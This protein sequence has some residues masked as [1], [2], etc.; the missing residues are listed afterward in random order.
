MVSITV[1]LPVPGALCAGGAAQSQQVYRTPISWWGFGMLRR[2]E[3]AA[4]ACSGWFLDGNK[5]LERTL[6]VT[7]PAAFDKGEPPGNL[8]HNTSQ[9]ICS[10]S[11]KEH[12]K[13]SSTPGVGKGQGG[14][15]WEC[16]DPQGCVQHIPCHTGR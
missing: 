7:D 12:E 15:E 16:L 10:K 13:C 8:H 1:C 14:A 11:W 9:K 2:G 5:W 6:W 3:A 4:P